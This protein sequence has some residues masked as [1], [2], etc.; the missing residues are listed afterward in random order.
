MEEKTPK[1]LRTFKVDFSLE[2]YQSFIFKAE[3]ADDLKTALEDEANLLDFLGI[4]SLS[5]LSD[6]MDIHI[7]NVDVSPTKTDCYFVD[8]EFYWGDQPPEYIYECHNPLDI[9]HALDGSTD[10]QD[11]Y[12]NSQEMKKHLESFGQTIFSF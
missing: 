10:A 6:D 2:F 11:S 3:S 9:L 8:K 12:W 1:I 5:E 7:R 4:Y